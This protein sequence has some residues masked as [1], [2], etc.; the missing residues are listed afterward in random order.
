MSPRMQLLSLNVNGLHSAEK[1][2]RVRYRLSR[3]HGGVLCIQET[4]AHSHLQAEEWLLARLDR[5]GS[6]SISMFSSSSQGGQRGVGTRGVATIVVPSASLRDP[7]RVF[8]S[9]D[10]SGRDDGRAL[11]IRV[12]WNGDPLVIC[13]VYAPSFACDRTAWFRD[14]LRP[15]L[16]QHCAGLPLLLVGDWNCVLSPA[17]IVGAGADPA[18]RRQGAPALQDLVNAL[19]LQD[20][21]RARDPTLRLPTHEASAG[22]LL[23]AARLDRVYCTPHLLASVVDAAI[24]FG[25]PG[26]HRGVTVSFAAPSAEAHGTAPWRLALRTFFHPD[27]REAVPR[28]A[29]Q[30]IR[31]KPLSPTRSRGQRWDLFLLAVRDAGAALARHHA[32]VETAHRKALVKLVSDLYQAFIQAQTEA[33]LTAWRRAHARLVAFETEAALAWEREQQALWQHGGERCTRWFYDSA[34]RKQAGSAHSFTHVA[35]HRGTVHVLDSREAAMAAGDVFS[36]FYSS[37]HPRGLF[38]VPD[39]SEETQDLYLHAAASRLSAADTAT[40]EGDPLAP[41]TAAELRRALDACPSWTAP[42]PD[43]IPY[44]FYKA[45]WDVVGEELAAVL[46]EAFHLLYLPTTMRG[47]TIILI[48]KDG[49][50]ERLGNYR[51]ITLLN[52]GYK[53]LAKALTIRVSQALQHVVGPQQTGFVPGRHIAE[54]I[55]EHIAVLEDCESRLVEGEA[56]EASGPAIAFLD[57]QK[58]YDSLHRGWLHRVLRHFGF[59]PRFCRWVEVLYV[60]S[61]CRVSYNNWL[62]PAFPVRSGVRQGC[63]LSPAL[64]VLAVEPLAAYLSSL[65]AC[66]RVLPYALLD[67]VPVP[68]ARQQADDLTLKSADGASLVRAVQAVDGFRAASG[69]RLKPDKGHLLLL[70]R[71]ASRSGPNTRRGPAAQTPAL[72]GLPPTVGP[73]ESVRHLGIRLCPTIA[74]SQAATYGAVHARVNSSAG[75]WSGAHLSLFG[76]AHVGKQVLGNTLGHFAACLAPSDTQQRDLATSIASFVAVG[77]S[78][79]AGASLDVP[80]CHQALPIH[81]GGLGAPHVPAIF[82]A[83]SALHVLRILAPGRRPL[84]LAGRRI[85]LHALDLHAGQ[86]PDLHRAATLLLTG[87]LRLFPAWLRDSIVALRAA[88]PHIRTGPLP[89]TMHDWVTSCPGHAVHPIIGPACQPW[90]LAPYRLHLHSDSH[91]SPRLAACAAALTPP[92]SNLILASAVWPLWTAPSDAAEWASLLLGAILCRRFAPACPI[93]LLTSSP[94]IARF[95]ASP[96][97]LRCA[98]ACLVARAAQAAAEG[99]H[100]QQPLPL[101]PEGPNVAMRLTD[102]CIATQHEQVRGGLDPTTQPSPSTLATVGH[103]SGTW[104]ASTDGTLAVQGPGH[105][106]SWYAVD[107]AGCL[108]PCPHPRAPLPDLAPAVVLHFQPHGRTDSSRLGS[109]PPLHLLGRATEVFLDPCRLYLGPTP[110]IGAR[111]RT[112]TARIVSAEKPPAGRG[113]AA[114]IPPRPVQPACWQPDPRAPSRL[115]ALDAEVAYRTLHGRAPPPPRPDW[116]AMDYTDTPAMRPSPARLHPRDRVANRPPPLLPFPTSDPIANPEGHRPPWAETWR[117]A[118]LSSIPNEAKASYWK[119]LHAA[120]HTPAWHAAFPA[121]GDPRHH[122]PLCRVTACSQ[123]PTPLTVRHLLWDCPVA[124]ACWDYASA[125]LSVA[126][127]NRCAITLPHILPSRPEHLPPPDIPATL[128]PFLRLIVTVMTHHLASQ[129]RAPL[130]PAVPSSSIAVITAFHDTLRTSIRADWLRTQL[131]NLLDTGPDAHLTRNLHPWSIAAFYAQWLGQGV[132]FHPV[133][134]RGRGGDD[135][136]VD[137]DLTTP[138]LADPFT[139]VA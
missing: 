73:G 66:G 18:G 67:A 81:L 44:A 30:H 3:L 129:P 36:E 6:F 87:P 117:F 12:L 113:P 133:P 128:L 56:P 21:H 61:T 32:G 19:A 103:A 120:L 43:G 41:V 10:A 85:L 40:C 2:R 109:E 137:L 7:L 9:Q 92:D 45:Y 80:R 71:R 101:S 132:W 97:P 115:V 42:G 139:G 35:D 60:D 127:G 104:R 134:A 111:V 51:P 118:K 33:S 114:G 78:V 76:S 15:L 49:A 5:R 123:T 23:T 77:R 93:L 95:M 116:S 62:S 121:A 96:I 74:A 107:Q 64:F 59:G 63:P 84:Q 119:V 108:A 8:A 135:L 50:R 75:R 4:H 88:Q 105:P 48:H 86:A 136:V 125:F 83:H 1:Q 79:P 126:S 52:C 100:L 38:A 131:D 55:L 17:D 110:A 99:L 70:G 98:T 138:V 65:Q 58:A 102:P 82:Q 26:D 29:L 130:H 54:N 94:D 20:V 14:T 34:R 89:H 16:A 28:L 25:L 69:L 27:F 72:A 91:G 11:A 106:L 68:I 22:G 124:H 13:N 53:I 57:F 31:G 90:P 122:D 46:N 24:E 39:V 37:D 47:G 112:L